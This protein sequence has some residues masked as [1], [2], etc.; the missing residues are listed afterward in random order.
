MIAKQGTIVITLDDIF[1]ND[2][3]FVGGNPGQD[4][5]EWAIYRLQ[6][7]RRGKQDRK[8]IEEDVM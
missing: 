3:T 2:F 7:F 6:S 8:P 4:A 5:I 1:V